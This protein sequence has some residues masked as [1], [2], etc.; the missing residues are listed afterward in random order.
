MKIKRIL[1]ETIAITAITLLGMLLIPSAKT[2]FAL[3]PVAYLLIERHLRRR[4]WGELGFNL[5]TFWDDLR[6][7]W[8]LFILLGF[9]IQPLVALWAKAYFP[10][11]LAHVQARLPFETG[12]AWG[13]LLP[14]L[15][16]SLIGEEMTY[17]TLIQGRL[18]PFIG[19]P[20][21]IGVA[22][23]LFGLAH[24]APGPGLI[25]L[26][27]IGLIIVDSILYGIMFARRHNLWVVWLA[28]LLGDIFGLFVLM[29][30]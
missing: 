21:A 17:R 26:T 30:V 13:V 11:F 28:H 9:V 10:S 5:H 19:T 2:L 8:M 7:N 22:S 25:V 23:L 18:T 3:V 1:F 4:T 12:I 24:F 14:L 29:S 6:A 27:D 20:A 15:A 16:F